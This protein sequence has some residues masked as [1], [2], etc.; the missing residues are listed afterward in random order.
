MNSAINQKANEISATISKVETTANSTSSKL[1][2]LIATVDGINVT[3]AKKTDKGSIISTINQSAETV[4][5]QANRLDL[6]G[7]VTIG[8][9]DTNVQSIIDG[10]KTVSYTHLDVY[11]RQPKKG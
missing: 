11:K 6:I 2:E 3:V 10:V 4:K 5:I 9:L 1:T 8:M 7:K